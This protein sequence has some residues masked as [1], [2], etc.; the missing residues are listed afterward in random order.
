MKRISVVALFLYL[1]VM[2]VGCTQE[3]RARTE[4]EAASGTIIGGYRVLSIPE[5]R[6]DIRLTVYRGDYVRF[7]YDGT[8]ARSVL[9][10]PELAI[11][12]I[13]SRESAKAPFFK[14]QQTG[15]FAFS[16]GSA[17]GSISVVEYRQPN[18][19]AVAAAQAAEL[20]RNIHPFILDVRT[21]QEYREGHLEN[22][23]LIPV[24]ELQGRLAELAKFK[25]ENILI[26]CATGNRS[27]VASKILID[28]GFKRIF[29]MRHGIHEWNGKKYPI[30]R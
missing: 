10:I 26:Y 28:N 15:T 24:Q 5:N 16:L 20:I 23:T 7:A 12:E 17:A 29:N 18:Y 14:M 6:Q 8:A 4:G 13:L 25:D 27:T 19:E 9:S 11:S 2:I 22:A 3:S 30:V 1:F 21:P